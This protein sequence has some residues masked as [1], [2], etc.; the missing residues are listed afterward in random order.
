MFTIA[1]KNEN[2]TAL[3]GAVS[4]EA[5][6]A[7]DL[8]LPVRNLLSALGMGEPLFFAETGPPDLTPWT[9][10]IVDEAP[11]SQYDALLAAVRA[12]LHLPSPAAALALT[13]RDFHGQ[14]GRPWRA[15][16]GNLHLTVYL[17]AE[18]PAGPNQAGLVALPALAARDAVSSE[19]GRDFGLGIKWVNDLLIS[20]RKIGGVLTSTQIQG[21]LIKGVIF[22]IGLN[23]AQAPALDPSPFTGESD[24]L[25]RHTN[26]SL[27]DLLLR[28]LAEF[29]RRFFDLAQNG[30]A[31]LLEDYRRHSLLL[32]REVCLWDE[33][34]PGEYGD[35]KGQPLGC[36][37]LSAIGDDLS[38]EVG[39]RIISRGRVSLAR[40]CERFPL[41]CP[42][43]QDLCH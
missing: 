8:D 6:A 14:R 26:I 18:I 17:K 30:P 3:L 35:L 41:P 12:G 9:L 27:S 38:L 33:E 36:G 21:N 42:F 37:V 2:L 40:P 43:K 10:V 25:G 1:D 28:L 22:G 13:G 19:A 15:L 31:A 4:P 11:S 24:C 32:G 20:D 23:L 34:A 29:Q 39:G 5:G 16:R 7:C